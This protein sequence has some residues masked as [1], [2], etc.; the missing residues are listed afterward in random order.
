MRA[1]GEDRPYALAVGEWP[2]RPISDSQGVVGRTVS[3]DALIVPEAGVFRYR[4]KAVYRVGESPIPGPGPD[5]IAV[6]WPLGGRG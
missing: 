4:A 2:L 6:K 1:A 5:R 3:C